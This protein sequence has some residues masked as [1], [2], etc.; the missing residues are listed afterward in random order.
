MPC[1]V[2]V[3]PIKQKHV[4]LWPIW[5]PVPA[6]YSIF[7]GGI[8]GWVDVEVVCTAPR[9][10][11]APTQ[12]QCDNGRCVPYA[13]VCDTDNDCG[14]MSDE[15][16]CGRKSAIHNHISNN[17]HTRRYLI[18]ANRLKT[19][20]CWFVACWL[21]LWNPRTWFYVFYSYCNVFFSFLFLCVFVM[22]FVYDLNNNN[23][24]YFF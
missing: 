7:R 2:K 23:N 12:F 9:P 1:L 11:C 18:S 5:P 22:Y 13:Y 4:E 24:Y 16:N 6:R 21:E 20:L 8:E 14:D 19:V 15:A 10:T 3:L 17:D